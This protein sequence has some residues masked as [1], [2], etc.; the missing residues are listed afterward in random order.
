M[1][2]GGGVG[3][4]RVEKGEG[5]GMGVGCY[6][7]LMKYS[8]PYFASSGTVARLRPALVSIK[9]LMRGSDSSSAVKVL[10]IPRCRKTRW[11]VASRWIL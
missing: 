6:R 4:G 10:I 11:S 5:E 9:Y 2:G 1:C 8:Q 7:V 3:F